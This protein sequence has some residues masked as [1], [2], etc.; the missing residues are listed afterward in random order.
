MNCSSTSQNLH[1]AQ[2]CAN[3]VGIYL[4]TIQNSWWNWRPVSQKIF[5]VTDAAENCSAYSAEL[6]YLKTI[7]NASILN[8]ICCIEQF[9]VQCRNDGCHVQI[10]TLYAGI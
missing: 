2:K 1:F 4:R 6:V 7:C 9:C 3:Y 10:S 5:K 8:N